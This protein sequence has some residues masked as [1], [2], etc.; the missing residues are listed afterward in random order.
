MSGR[1]TL[2]IAH[3]LSTILSADQILV[4]ERGEVVERGTHTQLLA[5]TGLY[6]KLFN[7]Q[8]ASIDDAVVTA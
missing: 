1:T 4:V 2:A 7:Q 3:R 5:Q 8:F 6:A